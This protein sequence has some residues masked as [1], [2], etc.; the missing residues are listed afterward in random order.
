MDGN[1]VI[2]RIYKHFENSDYNLY[3]SVFFIY[4][5]SEKWTFPDADVFVLYLRK[6]NISKLSEGLIEDSLSRLVTP[7]DN[8]AP[9]PSLHRSAK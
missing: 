4:I 2:L 8:I 1:F 7:Q 6:A 5:W 9:P 3:E